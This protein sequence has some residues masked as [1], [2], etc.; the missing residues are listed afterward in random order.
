MFR[1]TL[2]VNDNG[3][4]W[5]S[6]EPRGSVFGLENGCCF[7]LTP[8]TLQPFFPRLL[9]AYSIAAMNDYFKPIKAGFDVFFSLL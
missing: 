6:Q 9:I 4:Y 5:E 1:N 7:H 2:I 3:M 8:N